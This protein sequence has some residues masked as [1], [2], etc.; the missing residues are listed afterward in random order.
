M[1]NVCLNE[2]MKEEVSVS[3]GFMHRVCVS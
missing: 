2:C 1:K 3:S